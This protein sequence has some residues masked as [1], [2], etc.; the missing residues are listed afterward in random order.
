MIKQA[1][2]AAYRKLQGN[3]DEASSMAIDLSL[4]STLVQTAVLTLTLLVFIF[5]FRS[6]EK[7]IK[8]SS[9]QN[10]L[11]RYNDYVMS[12]T[13]TDDLLM[14]RLFSSSTNKQ[15]SADEVATIRRLMIAYGILEEAY[16]LYEKG[17]IDEEAWD[18]WDA[19]LR[20]ICKVPQF[21]MLHASTKGM[22]DRDFQDH[23]SRLMI[24]ESTN[25]LSTETTRK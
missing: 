3:R 10:V 7:A 1:Q 4:L 17:W 12:G 22:Y 2:I 24:G 8:E 13:G 20:D 18:Q 15:L 6:Q 19:W 5:Q 11:G 23:V 25:P 16:E 9:Y 21:A 14:A